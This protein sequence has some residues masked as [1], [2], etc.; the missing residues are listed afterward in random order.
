MLD[1]AIL[2]CMI[3]HRTIGV[4]FID[5]CCRADLFRLR[6]PP[7]TPGMQVAGVIDAVGWGPGA[8]EVSPR[9]RVA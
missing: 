1:G 6:Q 3:R 7:G 5:I 4:N 9:E 2:P 8:T